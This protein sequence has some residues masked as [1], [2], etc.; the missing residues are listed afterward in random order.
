MSGRGEP[1]VVPAQLAFLAIYNPSLG[2]TDDTLHDQVLYYFSRRGK[3]SRRGRR[4]DAGSDSQEGGDERNEQLRQI[5]LAQGTVEFARAFSEGETV[6]S[7]E[8]ERS[9]IIIHEL[10][11]GWWILASIALTRL[12][13]RGGASPGIE[14]SAREVSPPALL[15]QQLRRAHSVFLLHHGPNLQDI[16]HRL[17]RPRFCAA[18]DRYWMRFIR[19]WDVLLH[20]NPA[21]DVFRGIKLAAGGELGMGV[22]EEEWGSGERE[23][24]EG[25]VKRVDGLV[26]L[27]VSRSGKPEPGP[28]HQESTSAPTDGV[29]FSGVRAISKDSLRA[30][31]SW[32]E[33][34]HLHGDQAYGVRDNPN[35]LLRKRAGKPAAPRPTDPYGKAPAAGMQAADVST[36]S[37]PRIPPSI[38]AASQRAQKGNT[39]AQES[40]SETLMKFL[41]LGYGSSWGGAGPGP[42]SPAAADGPGQAGSGSGRKLLSRSTSDELR[43]KSKGRFLIGLQGDLENEDGTDDEAAPVAKATSDSDCEALAQE[44]RI[45]PRT[46]HVEMS[47][48]APSDRELANDRERFA[49]DP[50]NTFGG[51]SSNDVDDLQAN[52]HR[53]LRVVVYAYRPFIFTFLFELRTPALAIAS[54]YRSLHHQLG[55]LQRPL[56]ASTSP[57]NVSARI[58]SSQLA[59]VTSLSTPIFDLLYDPATLSIHS[60][61]PAIPPPGSAAAEGLAFTHLWTRLEALNVHGQILSTHAATRRKRAE[62]ERT[63]KT[64]RGWWVVWMRLPPSSSTLASSRGGA[65]AAADDDADEDVDKHREAFLVRKASDH[66][67]KPS[68]LFSRGGAAGGNA[69]ASAS[70]SWAPGKLAEGIGVDTRKYI[71]GLLSL[72]R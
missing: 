62:R 14:Y 37:A 2:N 4:N 9:R 17:S 33:L 54:F 45:L 63:C 11:R 5:G 32:A 18:L 42:S 22:G 59:A 52:Q 26:D 71:E 50:M 70:G 68:R 48:R 49:F 53:R 35:S 69:S 10:E 34:V 58:L 38:M 24:L 64:G 27:V 41:T 43:T 36:P 15:L 7:V 46:L 30:I 21:V 13:S 60:S 1:S 20:G 12:P 55:P 44:G 56:L 28:E 67:M 65:D 31:V 19:N 57:S 29:I 6:D 40:G 8:T 47:R 51:A 25:L 66:V 39:D 3:G 23:V 72:N 61:L 16:Y